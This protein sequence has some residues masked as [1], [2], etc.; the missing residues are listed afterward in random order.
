MDILTK[1]T[2]IIRD[3]NH[4]MHNLFITLTDEERSSLKYVSLKKDETLFHEN[5]KC[6]YVGIVLSGKLT[7]SSFTYNGNEIIYN[8]LMPTQVFGNNLIF[9]DKPFYRGEVVAKVDSALVLISKPQLIELLRNNEEFLVTYLSIQSNFSKN[10]NGQ[11][12]ML[13]FDSAEERFLF[14]LKMNDNKIQVHSVT[15][16]SH[17]LHLQRE[18]LSRL[19]SKLEKEGTISYQREKKYIYLNQ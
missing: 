6:E 10:L 7:I 1:Y 19:I 2:I 8:T 16:L 11:I 14:Y 9:S 5:D 3:L 13:S 15:D 12:K 18:T 17:E 4:S